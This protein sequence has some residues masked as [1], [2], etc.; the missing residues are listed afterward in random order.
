MTEIT[1]KPGVQNSNA[2]ALSRIGTLAKEGAEFDEIDPH[3]KVKILRENYVSILDGHRG[4]NKSYEAIKRYCQWPN[5]K[6][7]VEKYV[8]KYAQCQ[9]NKTL[10]R[11]RKAVEIRTTTRHPFEKGALDIVGPMTETISG[12]N[13]IFP[14]QDDL[15]K[16]RVVM[17]IPQQDEETLAK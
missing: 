2:D 13:Y 15:S 1:D 10:R 3:I 4:R 11:K 5:M 12:N 17:P 9:L 8:K 6:K 14:F 7:E 16:F